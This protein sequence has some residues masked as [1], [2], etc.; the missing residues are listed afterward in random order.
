MCR[1]CRTKPRGQ[2]S[3]KWRC[4]R[5]GLARSSNALTS[6]ATRRTAAEAVL[7]YLD[8]KPGMELSSQLVGRIEDRLWRAAR[9]LSY[10][11]SLGSPERRRPRPAADRAGRIR[12]GPAA[13][14]GVLTDRAGDAQDAGVAVEAGR[15]RRGYDRPSFR[16]SPPRLPKVSWSCRRATAWPRDEGCRPG[17]GG[18]GRIRGGA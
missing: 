13:G 10:K 2:P 17:N 8:L 12:R 7:R 4:W 16:S 1:W 11:V 14:A 3:C 15:E 5:R 18:P 6:S 9:F